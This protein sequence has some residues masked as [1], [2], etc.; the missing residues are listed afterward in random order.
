MFSGFGSAGAARQPG[1]AGEHRLQW[2][3]GTTERA[4][5]F[6]QDQVLDHL[7]ARMRE[8]A[9]EQEMFFIS[10]ADSRG[11]CDSSFRAGPPGV[12]HV[13]NEKALCYPEYRG[14]GV[15]ASLGNL[16]E[17]PHIGILMVDFAGDRIGL[18][19]N[20]RARLV[21]EGEMRERYAGLPAD[22]ARGRRPVVWVETEVEE[23]YIHCSKHIPRLVKAPM[24]RRRAWG[25]DDA[26]RKGGDYFGVRADRRGGRRWFGSR[27]GAGT[28]GGRPEA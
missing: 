4:E 13:L 21:P 17:N 19:V 22:Q 25:T 9:A 3:W 18:H 11:E 7:N 1:S 5:R 16:S 20:G 8:F 23:A 24:Q 28:A 27:S 14:N 2:D 12:L 10:T 6:Y 15:L 26:R